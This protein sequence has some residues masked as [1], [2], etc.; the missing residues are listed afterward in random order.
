MKIKEYTFQM[1][2]DFYAIMQCEHCG[3]E[4]E[5]KKGYNDGYYHNNVIPNMKCKKCN[6]SSFDS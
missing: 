5:N 2:N 4:Q 6:K 1:R 3:H